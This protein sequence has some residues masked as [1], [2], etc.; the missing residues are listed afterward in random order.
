MCRLFGLV[1]NVLVDVYFS[2][3]SSPISSFVELSRY[4]PHGWGVAWF[5]GNEWCLFK[6]AKALYESLKAKKVISK[7]VRGKI[8]I[9]HVRFA[10]TG[11]V[12]KVNTHPWIY[13]NWVFAHN[14]SISKLG[15]EKLIRSEYRDFEGG[16]DS[17]R[18]FHFMLQEIED[19]DDVIE[20][21]GNAISKILKYGINFSSLNC[22]FSNGDKLYALRYAKASPNYYTLYYIER[23]CEDVELSRLSK[24]T[25]Q[26]IQ[27]KLLRNE[28]A[29][30]I[31]SEPMSDEPVWRR[32]LN[33]HL[34]IVDKNLN[35][36]LVKI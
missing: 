28:K 27:M 9:S 26:L 12:K 13:K 30:I 10:T 6:E 18:L 33:K 1:S 34:L 25:R 29:I 19:T 11:S 3:Y 20:G 23:P 31:A 5:N 17:E 32:V 35:I 2:F 7:S 8:I 22:L 16:T 24:Q 14:G 21:I 4:N 15:L 36:E